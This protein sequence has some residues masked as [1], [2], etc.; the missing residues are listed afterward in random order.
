MTNNLKQNLYTKH[1]L[2]FN[3]DGKFTILM[4]SDIQDTM[5]YNMKTYYSIVKMLDTLKPDLVVL[6]GD[7]A[8]CGAFV[9]LREFNRYLDVFCGLFEERKIPWAHVFGNHDHDKPIPDLE[10]QKAYERF[11]YCVSKHTGKNVFGVTNFVLPVR[12]S[13][14]DEIALNVWGLDSNNRANDMLDMHGDIIECPRPKNRPE[15]QSKWDVVRFSQLQWYW[16]SSLEIEKYNKGKKPDGIMII[17]IPPHEIQLIKDNPEKLGCKGVTVEK[18]LLGTFNSGLFSTVFQRG[19]VHTIA[20]GHCHKNT[21]EGEYCGIMMCLDGATG[22]AP[23]GL[24]ET[25][26]G[27]AFVFDEN[28]SKRLSFLLNSENLL[29]SID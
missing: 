27:R 18:M 22:Y 11:D 10:K 4:L 25:R 1:P 16:Q 5:D 20:S 8:N 15:C 21:I 28:G 23:Y 24:K 26:G 2:R 9:S 17:H 14:S 3:K 29:K 13:D 19:D 7:N 6:G 12:R